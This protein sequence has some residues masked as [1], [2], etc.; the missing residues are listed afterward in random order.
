MYDLDHDASVQEQIDALPPEAL[1]AFAE[2]RVVLETAPWSGSPY[3]SE[4][5][6]RPVRA[7]A[8]GTAGLAVYL[9]MERQRRVQLVLVLWVG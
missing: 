7:H 8:F 3:H 2:L 1:A 9:V 5:P 6:D 4:D